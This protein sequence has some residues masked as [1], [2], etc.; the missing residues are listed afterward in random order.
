MD[1]GEK[2]KYVR[3]IREMNASELAKAADLSTAYISDLENGVKLSP[4]IEAVKRIAKALHIDAGY[5]VS[6]NAILPQ[7]VMEVPDALYR[8]MTD[9]EKLPYIELAKA[10]DEQGV[11]PEAAKKLLQFFLNVMEKEKA[12]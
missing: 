3:K 1:I 5:F 9:K 11:S 8:Y 4:S 12:E 2:I 7:Q 6:D 10:I